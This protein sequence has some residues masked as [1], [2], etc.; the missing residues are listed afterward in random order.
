MTLRLL[1]QKSVLCRSMS[2]LAASSSGVASPV[3]ASR[4]YHGGVTD[5]CLVH[6]RR[7]LSQGHWGSLRKHG[8]AYLAC[9]VKCMTQLMCYGRNLVEGSVEVT[10]DARFVYA[11][12]SHAES[13]ATF[14]ITR[15]R[16]NPMVIKSSLRELG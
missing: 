1:R 13:S 4:L 8:L 9:V 15:L 14:A 3:L 7:S 11:S 5:Y 16:V 10:E 2:N 6:D 12:Y